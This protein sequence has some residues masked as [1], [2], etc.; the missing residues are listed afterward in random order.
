MRNNFKKTLW[1]TQFIL[2]LF[3]MLNILSRYIYI[4]E[5]RREISNNV[6]CATI[7][8]SDQ[9]AHIRNMIRAFARCLN[10]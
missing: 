1:N 3:Y 4:Y 8:G 5:L 7:K 9:P 6:V 10:I 2:I